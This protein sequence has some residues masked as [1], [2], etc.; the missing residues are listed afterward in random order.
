MLCEKFFYRDSPI[1]MVSNESYGQSYILLAPGSG[2]T[3]N[4]QIFMSL[5]KRIWEHFQVQNML[6]P[7]CRSWYVCVYF[8][9]VISLTT[10]ALSWSR[11]FSVPKNIGML[12]CSPICQ[13]FE[14]VPIWGKS[15][16]FSTQF[17]VCRWLKPEG[18]RITIPRSS[19]LCDVSPKGNP[20]EKCAA[21]I[22]QSRL[23]AAAF[24]SIFS[25]IEHY[26]SFPVKLIGNS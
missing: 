10:G 7:N 6:P 14:L 16:E 26:F 9:V 2:S 5:D 23:S 15:P 22:H 8:L 1:T 4:L 13:A 20:S 21:F 17:T 3:L 19:R 11:C 18:G 12:K 24:K 25:L